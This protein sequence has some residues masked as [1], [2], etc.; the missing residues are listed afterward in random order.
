MMRLKEDDFD[1]DEECRNPFQYLNG[2][3]KI[4]AL[5]NKV[6]YAPIFQ[7]LYGA[8][9]SNTFLQHVSDVST[10]Q[11]LYGAIKRS[12]SNRSCYS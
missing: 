7:Y 12:S 6:Y 5:V 9:R 4:G 8:V 11:Y 3:V 1:T 10:F 2:A